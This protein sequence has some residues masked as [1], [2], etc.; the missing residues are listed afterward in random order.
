MSDNKLSLLI[1]RQVPEFVL[2]ENPIFVSFLE[3]YYEFLENAQ[4]TKKNDLLTKSKDL[5]YL[6]DVDYSVDEFEESFF[7]TYAELIPKD[8]AVNKE[9]LIKNLLPVYLAK[10]SEKSFQLLFRMLFGQELQVQ[11]PKSSILRASDGK[12]KIENA[13]KISELIHS[14]HTGDGTTKTFYLLGQFSADELTIKKNGV[15]QTSG[16]T[17]RKESKKLIFNT[18]PSTSDTIDVL[19]P[20]TLDKNIFVNRKVTGK[21]SGATGIVE[22]VSIKIVNQKPVCEL[23]IDSKTLLGTFEIGENV[24]TNVF[25]DNGDLVNVRFESISTLLSINIITG[26]ANYNVGDPAIVFSEDAD[27]QATAIISRTF[28]GTV[29]KTTVRDGGAG[30][31]IA[32]RVVPVGYS[33]TEMDF[34][35]SAVDTTG[36]NSANVFTIFSD[37]IS[38]IDPSNT[39]I[40]ATNYHFPATVV[41]SENVNT[42]IAH[43]LSNTTYIAIGEID[44][45]AIVANNVI[46]TTTPTLNAEPATVTIEPLTANTSVNTEVKIDTFGSVGKII[47]D[48]PGYNYAVG[49]QL[50]FTNKPMCFGQGAEGEV[51]SVSLLGRITGVALR[52]SK[53][54]GTANVTSLSNVMV[55]GVGTLFQDELIVGDKIMINGQTKTVVTIASNTSLNVNSTFTSTFNDKPVRKWGKNLLGGQGYTQDKLPDITITSANGTGGYIVATA[56]M[57]D[58]EDINAEG[59]KKLGEIEEITITNPGSGFRV[60]PQVD[61]TLFG[62]GTATANATLSPTFETFEGRFTSSDGILSSLDRKLQGRDYYHDYSYLL[63]SFVEFAKYKKLFNELLH[64]A[65]FQMFAELNHMDELTA[66]PASLDTVVAPKTI[67]TLSGTVNVNSSVIVIGTGTKFNVANSHGLL[68]V[69][70]YIAVNSEI[71]VVNSIVNNTTI[72]VTSPF[73]I[74]ANGQELIVMNTVYDAVATE[75]TLDEIIAENELVLTVES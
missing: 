31:Q 24:K 20:S 16:F 30:F 8:I 48:E 67:R 54:T 27:E 1:S 40:S 53:I 74:T 70:S 32:K 65:G 11:Y 45:V 43:A 51:T 10:G 34:T 7:N 72:T 36:A 17:V 50:V 73:T 60:V 66:T 39:L 69:G 42:V 13:I 41:A 71:R 25:D 19:Y 21:N 46:V 26:G 38:D 2:D 49:D 55:H 23:F 28:K 37:I 14:E 6:S 9:I 64:P 61:L 12:W 29:N 47:I 58:G 62:D 18:A 57:G 35:I 63:S 56:I 52:P 4:G 44:T 59:T 3:A 15:V 68:T 75:V 5:R 22:K 33:N